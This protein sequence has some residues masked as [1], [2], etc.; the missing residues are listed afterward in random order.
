MFYNVNE[1]HTENDAL[2]SIKTIIANYVVDRPTANHMAEY[3]VENNKD[4]TVVVKDDFGLIIEC[5]SNYKFSLFVDGLFILEED[6]YI[7]VYERAL[8]LDNA[9]TRYVE[10]R[11]SND[12]KTLIKRL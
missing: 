3:W 9:G 6:S 2:F 5:F 7:T 8:V 12:Q 11:L 4:A 1:I 10:I